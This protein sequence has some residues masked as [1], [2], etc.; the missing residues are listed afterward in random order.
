MI[1]KEIE[2]LLPQVTK[3]ARYIGGEINAVRK[4]GGADQVRVALAFPDTYEVGMSHLGLKILYKVINDLPYAAAER[5]FAPWVDMAAKMN[6]AKV[7]LYGL[8][9]FSPI[10][11]FDLVGFTL[12]Y[13]LSY[14]NILLML[15]LSGIPLLA[16]DRGEQHPLIIAGGPTAYNVEPL[17]DVLDAVV[18]GEGEEVIV[19]IIQAVQKG[20][21]DGST[22]KEMLERLTG[23]KGVYV[24]SL[25]EP[26]Y[27][28]DATWRGLKRKLPHLPEIVEK[29]VV[30]EL[31]PNYIPTAPV[32]P[33]TEII[34][35]RVLLEIFRGCA[36]GCRFCQAGMT[37]RPVREFST[38]TLVLAAQAA[39]RNTGYEEVSL[40][41]L[42][43]MDHSGIESLVRELVDKLSCEG[44]NISL[45]SLRVDSFSVQL[46]AEVAR[47]R[48]SGITLAP[49]AGSQRLRDVI[50]KQ[51]TAEGLLASL[52]GAK[53][54]GFKSVKL[55]FMLGLP[56]ETQS[57]LDEMLGLIARA[58][59]ILPVAVSV[60]S[61]VPKPHTPFQ[62]EPQAA[63]Q[64]LEERQQYLRDRLR[65]DRRV[66]FVYHDASTSFLEAVFSRGDRR[67]GK[68]LIAAYR[69]G[70]KFDAWGEHFRYDLWMEA[71]AEVGLDPTWYANRERHPEE[72][73]PWEHL[74]P[75]VT[76]EFLLA[77]KEK[78]GLAMLT[79][80]CAAG[81]CVACGVC[82]ALAV[83]TVTERG[84]GQ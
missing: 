75:G 41:S 64:V 11:E 79:L 29:R 73:F 59:A 74:S 51:V 56:T 47:V 18:L 28:E 66:K 33:Y 7:K 49:E 82:T 57:D 35:D 81:T 50:N 37:Y 54:L 65:R 60:S 58:A 25:Y 26:L 15:D 4:D 77:E 22:R 32:L 68:V 1:P 36:R 9:S 46:A 62:W 44:V 69:L 5:V 83:S 16:K 23:V 19:E 10:D 27:H 48:K 70:C 3:P 63:M 52:Q 14:T 6:A 45:P 53:R 80:D 71:F 38:H 61:F 34:H 67:L 21:A 42:S 17:A 55:Y 13:E 20:K 72:Q 12:Q 39:I 76:R 8:E 84:R 31:S 24:P 40:S 2:R 43:T 30:A 78:A